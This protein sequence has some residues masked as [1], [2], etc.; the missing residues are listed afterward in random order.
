MKPWLTFWQNY[1][2][3]K[4]NRYRY[5]F[6]SLTNNIQDMREKPLSSTVQDIEKIDKWLLTSTKDKTYFNVK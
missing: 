6:T 2:T 1:G 3:S 5:I 4:Y